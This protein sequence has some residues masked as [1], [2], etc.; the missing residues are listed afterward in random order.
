MLVDSYDI[1][2]NTLNKLNKIVFTSIILDN[3]KKLYANVIISTQPL[4]FDRLKNYLSYRKKFAPIEFIKEKFK[5]R[6]TLLVSMGM[7]D[8]KGITLK[9]NKSIKKH[10]KKIY[11]L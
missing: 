11:K 8:S 1:K 6:N 2:K 5:V 9:N 7:Y 10:Y 4:K 3:Y